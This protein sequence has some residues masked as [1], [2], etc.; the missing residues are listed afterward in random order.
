MAAA[1]FFRRIECRENARNGED[2][3]QVDFKGESA[4]YAAVQH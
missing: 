1:T 2:A 4:V 3:P